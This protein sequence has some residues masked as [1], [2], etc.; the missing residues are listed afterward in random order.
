MTEVIYWVKDAETLNTTTDPK[1]VPKGARKVTQAQYIK[2]QEEYFTMLDK[3]AEEHRAEVLAKK[4]A[5]A[6][7]LVDNS[8]VSP[9]SIETLFGVK[10]EPSKGNNG[11]GN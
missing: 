10:V 5:A 1:N 3:A 8:G 11:Y 2:A 7:D 6:Q 9:E 4:T